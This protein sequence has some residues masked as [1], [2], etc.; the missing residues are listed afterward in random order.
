MARPTADDL[1]SQPL[2]SRMQR[3]TLEALAAAFEI[4]THTPGHRIVGEGD[5]GYAFYVVAA[6]TVLVRRGDELVRRLGP[7][8]FFGEVAMDA[9]PDGRRSATV[10]A[11]TATTLWVMFGT[12][13]RELQ[14][15]QPEMAETISATMRERLAED[16][17]RG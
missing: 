4:E 11:E 17:R 14:M 7:G 2:F 8:D 3:P 9:R 1:A 16:S 13:F 6:G 5:H 12:S 10:T 15:S